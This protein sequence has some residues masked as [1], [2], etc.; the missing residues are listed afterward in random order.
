[1]VRSGTVR[2]ST[3]TTELERLGP[4]SILGEMALIE[5]T[6]R[7]ATVTAISDCE[8]ALIDRQ[9]FLFLVQ[10]TPSFALNVMRVLSHRLREMNRRYRY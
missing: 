10:Q 5:A 6:P 3:G 8:I 2:V 9:R 4:G 1:V 7:S